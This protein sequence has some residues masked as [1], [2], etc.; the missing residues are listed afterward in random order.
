MQI[1]V[2]DTNYEIL[3]YID[4]TES[5]LWNK[6]YNDLGESE[7]YIPC[8]ME[9][10]SILRKG[11]Y[12]FRFDD[13]M[14]CKIKKVEI[15]TDVENGDYII[16]TAKD[17]SEI[18]AG[19]IVRWNT[20]FSGKVVHF[21]KKLIEDNVIN[22]KDD[23]KQSH[24]VRRI[25]NFVFDMTEGEMEQFTDTINVTANAD[26]LLQR[27]ITTCKAF[28]YG[29]RTSLDID[30]KTLKF[31]LFKGVNR[32]IPTTD[33]Y[34]EFSPAYGNIISSKYET[35]DSNYK[36]VAYVGYKSADKDDEKIYLLSVHNEAVEPSGENRREIYVDGTNTSRDITY[37]EL[38]QMF[39][40]VRKS[41]N[42]YY[43]S[44]NISVAT[45]EGEGEDEKITITDYTYLLLI[46]TIGYDTL[47]NK[48]RT[49]SFS[50]EVDMINSYRYKIDYD[51]GDIVKVINE[52][53]IEANAQ[54]F[55]IM[56]SEDNDNGYVAEPSFQYVS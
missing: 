8:D 40:N 31:R 12:L 27:I 25:P 28:N 41:G 37:E 34:V 45:S 42:V 32:T 36:N 11:H 49:E 1:Y 55:E 13:D 4:I 39:P 53:G 15:E 19:R 26:D 18:L 35:D 52:Y 24:T 7:I 48:K 23:K 44:Q 29:F 6:K 51:I 54:V 2:L 16:A 47:E 50:G 9:M 46:R 22:P 43:N 21:I 14:L 30:T 56:E 10:L 3:S 38:A 5:T 20:T 17:M 33:D